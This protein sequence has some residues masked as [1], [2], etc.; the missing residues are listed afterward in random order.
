MVAGH[1]RRCCQCLTLKTSAIRHDIKTGC[2]QFSYFVCSGGGRGIHKGEG[3]GL[4]IGGISFYSSPARNHMLTITQSSLATHL[5]IKSH[6]VDAP[7]RGDRKTTQRE[8]RSQFLLVRIN[9]IVPIRLL[10]LVL[11]LKV[12][13]DGDGAAPSSPH[14]NPILL[15][16]TQFAFF[17]SLFPYKNPQIYA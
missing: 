6:K 13:L 1:Y 7:R 8:K 12:T 11:V 3:G 17:K 15:S 16:Q 9:S 2:F 10:V 4:S 5:H 14:K